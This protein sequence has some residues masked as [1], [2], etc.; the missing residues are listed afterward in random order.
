M[1]IIEGVHQGWRTEPVAVI[2]NRFAFLESLGCP[3]LVLANAFSL[4]NSACRWKKG[5]LES[6]NP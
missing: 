2:S 5:R 3:G 1:L 6:C 4:K